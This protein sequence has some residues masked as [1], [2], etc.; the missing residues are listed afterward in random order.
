M[1]ILM[2]GLMWRHPFQS[3]RDRVGR[4]LGQRPIPSL[5]LPQCAQTLSSPESAVARSLP[6]VLS[7]PFLPVSA[8]STRVPSSPAHHPLL[9]GVSQP[10]SPGGEKPM[11]EG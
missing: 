5:C 1:L 8:S 2:G 4:G 6:Q 11:G 10:P 7:P 3:S 9:P